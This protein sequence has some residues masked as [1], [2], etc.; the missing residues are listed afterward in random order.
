MFSNI[1]QQDVITR[2][3]SSPEMLLVP[4]FSSNEN[5]ENQAQP[6][7]ILELQKHVLSQQYEGTKLEADLN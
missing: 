1:L 2:M 5:D 3:S 4:Y 7:N 6:K